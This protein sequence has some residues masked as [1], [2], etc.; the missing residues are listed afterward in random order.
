MKKLCVV[1]D[2]R[3]KYNWVLKHPKMDNIIG[4]FKDP[5][6]AVNWYYSFKIETLVILFN[7]ENINVGEI[8]FIEDDN[9]G[10]FLSVAQA[11]G[12]DYNVGYLTLCKLFNIDPIT[13][14]KQDSD[15]KLEEVNKNLIFEYVTN[16]HDYFERKYEIFKKPDP[17]DYLNNEAKSRIIQIELRNMMDFSQFKRKRETIVIDNQK[18]DV[19][20][21][22]TA[23]V[24]KQ[25]QEIKKEVIIIEEKPEV[26]INVEI[27]KEPRKPDK[28]FIEKEVEKNDVEHLETVEVKNEKVYKTDEKE[29]SREKESQ[30][31]KFIYDTSTTS[32]RD[33]IIEII[34]Q[35]KTAENT[36]TLPVK[37]KKSQL[38]KSYYF[39]DYTADDAY[40]S[41]EPK[42]HK[43][44]TS[45][46]Y[47]V[48][49]VDIKAI[50][51]SEQGESKYV[52]YTSDNIGVDN[53]EKDSSKDKK[54]QKRVITI[55][56]VV[57]LLVGLL[58][59]T[60]MLLE[61][62][63]IVNIVNFI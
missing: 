26:N 40:S 51:G 8:A 12:N 18:I 37:V 25:P 39:Y 41:I 17:K 15:E 61:Y 45:S 27:A 44:L 60:W 9:T 2:K 58:F 59:G 14:I 5:I 46:V 53:I 7:E 32:V 50:E 38:A 22:K 48:K 34:P 24:D 1:Y 35:I 52:T 57:L 28:N 3:Y 30:E 29:K 33:E 11:S 21:E 47:Y 6:S 23:M 36:E 43:E 19:D 62:L 10:K 54:K 4:S 63:N 16:P 13:F 42:A 31:V 56:L 20:I 55:V 49:D